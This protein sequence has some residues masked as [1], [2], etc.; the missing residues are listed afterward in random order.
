MYSLETQPTEPSFSLM[1]SSSGESMRITTY[2]RLQ[3][4]S[5]QRHGFY[6]LEIEGKLST[7]MELAP[8]LPMRQDFQQILVTNSTSCIPHICTEYDSLPVKSN[9]RKFAGGYARITHFMRGDDNEWEQCYSLVHLGDILLADGWEPSGS[10]AHKGEH[11]E[12]QSTIVE[13]WIKRERHVKKWIKCSNSKT[14][15]DLIILDIRYSKY[16]KL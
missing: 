3:L 8:L 14:Y 2:K 10:A 1:E 12:E 16:F 13:T 6:C 4:K 15:L 7:L 11:E 5:S 9:V